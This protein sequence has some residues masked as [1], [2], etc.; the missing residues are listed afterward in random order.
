MHFVL[1][2]ANMKTK[3]EVRS[4]AHFLYQ[5]FMLSEIKCQKI[6]IGYAIRVSPK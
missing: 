5:R 2:Q 3:K 6:V 1:V 4:G